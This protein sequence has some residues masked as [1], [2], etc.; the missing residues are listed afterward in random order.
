MDTNYNYKFD[1]QI[2]YPLI[3]Y[4]FIIDFDGF[5]IFL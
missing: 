2:C 1:L 4:I 3:I 5:N